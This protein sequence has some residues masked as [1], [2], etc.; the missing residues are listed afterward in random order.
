MGRCRLCGYGWPNF[1]EFS[2]CP[3]CHRNPDWTDCKNGDHF[4][5]I[6]KDKFY[7]ENCGYGK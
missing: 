7:C 3:S 6:Y 5:V 2:S 1:A 4:M